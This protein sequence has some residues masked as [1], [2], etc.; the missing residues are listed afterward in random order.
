MFEAFKKKSRGD[1]IES[2]KGSLEEQVTNRSRMRLK[3]TARG[4]DGQS[5]PNQKKKKNEI[6]CMQFIM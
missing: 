6:A 1:K 5:T 4:I 2:S 3:N